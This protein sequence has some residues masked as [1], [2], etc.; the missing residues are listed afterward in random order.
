MA[1]SDELLAA[2]KLR[3]GWP[4]TAPV[5]DANLLLLADDIIASELWPLLKSTRGEYH[6][7]TAEYAITANRASYRI[8]ARAIYPIRDVRY[9]DTVSGKPENVPQLHVEDIGAAA[10]GD[11]FAFYLDGDFITLDP[12]PT[13]TRGTLIIRYY[14]RP[15]ALTLSANARRIKR[16][17]SSTQVEAYATFATSAIANGSYVDFISAS[18]GHQA[19]DED[20]LVTGLSTVTLTMSGGYSTKI[21]ASGTANQTGDWV[22]LAGFTPVVQVPDQV[23]P[24]LTARVAWM[25]LN[26]VGDQVRMAAMKQHAKEID[27]RA[28][29]AVMPRSEAEPT[30]VMQRNGLLGRIAAGRFL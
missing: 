29:D 22:A 15:N 2:V 3:C 26:A 1:T 21:E 12:M 7:A 8:P 16:L 17:P 18:G 11:P 13:T 10:S 20:V 28:L 25:A 23:V 24:L 19:L 5:S 30:V 27:S 14:R 9:R 6:T 4:T